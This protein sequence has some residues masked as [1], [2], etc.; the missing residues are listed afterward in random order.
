LDPAGAADLLQYVVTLK[1]QLG[2]T[3]LIAEHR[4]ERLLTFADQLIYLP[5][6]GETHQGTPQ[7]MLP[8]MDQIPPI[9]QIGKALRLNPLPLSTDA[10]PEMHVQTEQIKPPSARDP[11]RP[12]L[13]R[14]ASLSADLGGRT[15]LK[16][17]DL[18]LIQGQVT[19]LMGLNGAGKTTLLRAI[20]GLSPSQG[21][22]RLKGRDMNALSLSEVIEQIAYLP[23]NP[24][25]LLFD[26][27]VEE[28]LRL[29]LTNHSLPID[30]DHIQGH[31]TRFGLED[32][33]ARYPRDLSVGERQRTALAAITVHDPPVIL[34][35]EPTR[36]LDYTNKLAIAALLADWR[37]QGKAILVTTHDVEFAAQ[38]ADSVIILNAGEIQ[39][40]G[41]P[42]PAF[43]QF[44][45]FRT[46]TA[47]LFPST[48]WYRPQHVQID[49]IS[50]V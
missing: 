21:E 34:L 13:L 47:N 39:Y 43:T 49:R 15:V 36:G 23:Q 1:E 41:D 50:N 16:G 14:V 30:S 44:S 38:L 45:D 8:L 10:F 32:K 12:D 11:K 4:L 37:R 26:D 3:V 18:T 9:V 29:T 6:N 22:R 46:Q 48:G 40:Q 5:G 7:E 27:S 17:I 28:E 19:V 25:D 31:L 33:A 20:M 2:L 24:A 35:D 42:G